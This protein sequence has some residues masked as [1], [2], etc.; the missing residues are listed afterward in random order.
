M[1]EL[2]TGHFSSYMKMKLS[3][4][5]DVQYVRCVSCCER[6][7]LVFIILWLTASINVSLVNHFL[8]SV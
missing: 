7:I 4:Y 1:N 2:H 3:M 5:C 6:N 8:F